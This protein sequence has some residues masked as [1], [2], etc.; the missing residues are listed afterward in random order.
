MCGGFGQKRHISERP[1]ASQLL[2]ALRTGTRKGGV[3]L[4]SPSGLLALLHR[5][6][7]GGSLDGF[8]GRST[9]DRLDQLAIRFSD[10]GL[11]L[12]DLRAVL[13]VRRLG[14]SLVGFEPVGRR[15]DERAAEHDA[16]TLLRF[17]AQHVANRHSEPT[18]EAVAVGLVLV[19]VQIEAVLGSD[20]EQRGGIDALDRGASVLGGLVA[21]LAL[22]TDSRD[23][24]MFFG[25]RRVFLEQIAQPFGAV[26][27]LVAVFRIDDRLRGS[28]RARTVVHLLSP[29]QGVDARSPKLNHVNGVAVK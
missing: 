17:G 25:Q 21:F 9:G 10:G 29:L 5:L 7:R 22:F 6:S 19:L 8:L 4:P 11:R 16:V 1:E 15:F 20:R 13:R 18:G 2:G 24:G 14:R 26:L 27:V 12:G 23:G 3:A 28:G